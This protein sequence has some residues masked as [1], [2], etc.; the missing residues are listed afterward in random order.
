MYNTEEVY[1]LWKKKQ[2]HLYRHDGPRKRKVALFQN[3]KFLILEHWLKIQL[4]IQI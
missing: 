2:K 3:S 4:L 1:L